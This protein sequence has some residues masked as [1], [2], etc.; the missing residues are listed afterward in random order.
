M[1]RAC[2]TCDIQALQHIEEIPAMNGYGVFELPAP[3][4]AQLRTAP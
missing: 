3:V 4:K 2:G 1:D